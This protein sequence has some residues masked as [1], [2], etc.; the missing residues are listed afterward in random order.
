MTRTK[1]TAEE[2]CRK[3]IEEFKQAKKYPIVVVLDNIRSMN[4]VG[5]IFRTCDAFLVERI[6]LCGIT[7]QPPQIGRAHV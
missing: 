4:N 6:L 3:S 1:L 7:P 2:L 5:S